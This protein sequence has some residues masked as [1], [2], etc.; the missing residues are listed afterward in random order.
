MNSTANIVPS[1]HSQIPL[2]SSRRNSSTLQLLRLI[3]NYKVY[4][5]YASIAIFGTVAQFVIFKGFYP[6]PDFIQDS[7]N[8]IDTASRHLNANVLAVG[9]GKILEM[10]HWISPADTFL[11]AIQYFSLEATFA[12][13]FFSI[14]YLF[15]TTRFTR[16]ILFIFL[17]FNPLFLFMSNCILPDVLFI[18]LSILFFLQLLWLYRYPSIGR[19]ILQGILIGLAFTLKYTAIYYP[20]LS[21]MGLW[22]TLSKPSTKFM[23]SIVGVVLILAFMLYTTYETRQ[24]IGKTQFSIFGGWQLANN[25]LYMYDHIKVDGTKLPPETR[26]LDDLVRQ[27][28]KTV[29]PEKRD[30]EKFSGSF[31]IVAPYA[32][33]RL[34]MVKKYRNEDSSSAVKLFGNVSPVMENYGKSLITRHPTAYLKYFMAPN[35]KN[36]FFP[37]LEKM[38]TYN[39]MQTAVPMNIQDWFNYISND[40][41]AISNTF[42]GRLFRFYPLFFFF[43]NIFFIFGLLSSSLSGELKKISPQFRSIIVLVTGFLTLHALYHIATVPVVLRFQVIPMIIMLSFA[44]LLIQP[45]KE[46]I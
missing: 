35:V 10:V 22:P 7:Y 9:Y 27:F 34:Y 25:A 6:Y 2:R 8:Y 12:Y 45:K 33:L 44:L 39:M 42:Q 13:F 36:Y 19:A 17:F 28:F 14:L 18:V 21:I 26:D 37:R 3:L 11:I 20:L 30:L 29:P 40:I 24:L 46:I 32:P 31:F 23:G 4:R 43:L 15:S 1:L 5:L 16:I 38:E 41:W